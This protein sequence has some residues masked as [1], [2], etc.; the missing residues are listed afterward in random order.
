VISA[1][2]TAGKYA[3]ELN[4]ID[5]ADMVLF[6]RTVCSINDPQFELGCKDGAGRGND[7]AT[8]IELL[9]DDT[10]YF[11]VG[12]YGA[13]DVGA[14]E[15]T[16]RPIVENLASGDACDAYRICG[17][18]LTCMND[19]CV[20]S[21]PMVNSASA[22]FAGYENNL[23]TLFIT[24]NGMDNDMNSSYADIKV[25]DSSDN[26]I[27]SKLCVFVGFTFDATFSYT[28]S[29]TSDLDLTNAAK[30]SI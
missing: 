8:T 6:A 27:D 19:V 13:S 10:V 25:W 18:G 7:E 12:A 9:A 24:I 3:V 30:V 20:S 29:L 23:S 17:T 5:Q 26:V 11:Y 4:V 21:V 2:L 28:Y 15:L 1:T 14:Y 16:V 22:Y